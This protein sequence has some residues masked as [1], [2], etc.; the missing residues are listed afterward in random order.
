MSD[1]LDIRGVHDPKEQKKQRKAI[2][3]DVLAQ[4]AAGMYIPEH[5]YGD[6]A[7]WLPINSSPPD[8]RAKDVVLGL[9]K[10]CE[11]CAAGALFVSAL[12][13][14]NG[15]TT[16][17][18]RSEE[19]EQVAQTIWKKLGD[20]FPPAQIG[21]IEAAFESDEQQ[22]LVQEARMHCAIDSD[23]AW[24]AIYWGESKVETGS[25][26]GAAFAQKMKAIMENIVDN[27]G[28]FV[29]PIEF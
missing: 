6:D 11:I 20:Y 14:Y 15:S 3:I 12:R 18:I 21:L 28:D 29:V 19:M 26:V 23:E 1:E 22:F 13:L 8:A 2:A 17:E 7:L 9:T 27:D 4:M 5:S 16:G 24:S 25:M 10:P